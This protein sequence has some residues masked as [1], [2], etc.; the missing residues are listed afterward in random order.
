WEFPGPTDK[1]H[2]TALLKELRSQLDA[3]GV[4]DGTHYR[5]TAALPASLDHYAHVELGQIAQYLDWINLMA[6]DFYTASSAKTHFSAPL[7]ASSADPEPDPKKRSSSNV[8]AAVRAYLSA[9][10]PAGKIVLG[11]PFFGYGWEGVSNVNHGLYQATT[12]PAQGT[13]QKDGVFDF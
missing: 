5:L 3:Q 4:T 2:Y 13:W 6:Y 9:G 8:D 10:V 11:V 1:P 12:G 7:Y